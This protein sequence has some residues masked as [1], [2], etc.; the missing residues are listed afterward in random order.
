[1]TETQGCLHDLKKATRDCANCTSFV[2]RILRETEENNL[3][4]KPL[5][6]SYEFGFGGCK[7]EA[8]IR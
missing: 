7:L 1:M 5:T 4:H 8:I 6:T 2:W 3:I